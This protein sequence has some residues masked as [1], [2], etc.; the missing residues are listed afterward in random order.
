MVAL[1]P[2]TDGVCKARLSDRAL[3]ALIRREGAYVHPRLVEEG[4]VDLEDLEGLGHVEVAELH[5][6][7]GERVFVPTRTG[8]AVLEVA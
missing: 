6:L 7:P 5:P 3:E 2:N 4:W 1:L 8:W